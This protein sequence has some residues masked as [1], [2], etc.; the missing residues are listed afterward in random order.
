MLMKQEIPLLPR[1]LA[2]GTFGKLLIV[3]SAKVNLLYLLYNDPQVFYYAS[4]K[5]RLFAKNFSKNLNL[6]DLGISL[7]V[8]LSMG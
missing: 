2:L 4:D 8:F 7:P 1:N 3:F 5:A 6:D